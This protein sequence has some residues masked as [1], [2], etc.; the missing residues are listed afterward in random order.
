MSSTE[1]IIS[2]IV[3]AVVVDWVSDSMGWSLKWKRLAISS[4]ITAT[5]ISATIKLYI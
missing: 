3:I 1:A 4:I 2:A 5:I